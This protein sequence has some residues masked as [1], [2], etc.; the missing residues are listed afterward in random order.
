MTENPEINAEVWE[1]Q[2]VHQVRRKV[3]NMRHIL[4]DCLIT[5]DREN[6]HYFKKSKQFKYGIKTLLEKRSQFQS[7]PTAL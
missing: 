6:Q 7:P 1:L 5:N 4:N 2:V 3:T